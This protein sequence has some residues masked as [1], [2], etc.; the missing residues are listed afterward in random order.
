MEPLKIIHSKKQCASIKSKK[1]SDIRCPNPATAKGDFTW[2]SIHIKSQNPWNKTI[3]QSLESGQDQILQ[4]SLESGQDQILQQ[5]V[6]PS[7]P[8]P[9]LQLQEK[10]AKIIQQFW[11]CRGRH[12]L[13]Q[14]QG[15]C[16]YIPQ[17]AHNEKD[18]YSYDTVENIPLTYRFS[19]FDG[20][21]HW[22]F[23]IR[24]LIQLLQYG[25]DMKNPFTQEAF[26]TSI[27]ERIRVRSEQLQKMKK[28][29]IYSEEELTSEQ[30]WNQKVL[31][32][33][34]KMISLGYGVNV[35]WFESLHVR[36]QERFYTEMFRLW[37]EVIP[38]TNEDRERI[39]PGY[40]SGRSSLFRWHPSTITQKGFPI[41]WWRKQNLKIMNAFLTRSNEKENQ[42]C[43]CLYILRALANIHPRAAEAFP[44]LVYE[45]D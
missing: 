7:K 32:V 18:I 31:D 30:I 16:L 43:G 1:Q 14:F 22:L 34:L 6:E 13:L 17:Q 12:K 27:F 39:V 4:Q 36:G 25:S 38:L 19:I 5:I 21:H 28:P 11:I 24:F 20:A 3:Q 33:F 10:S 35:V 40:N 37:T 9:N 26:P 29:T 8:K 23:D 41:K 44:W 42:T 2:C 45:N 15:I